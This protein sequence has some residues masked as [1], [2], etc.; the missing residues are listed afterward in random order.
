MKKLSSFLLRSPIASDLENCLPL[1]KAFHAETAEKHGFKFNEDD[2]KFI[3]GAF[4]DGNGICL[5]ADVGDEVAGILC[6]TI[7]PYPLCMS[8]NVFK[9]ILWYVKPEYRGSIGRI[10]YEEMV[11]ECKENGV[12]IVWFANQENYMKEPLEHFY[13]RNGFNPL[14]TSWVKVI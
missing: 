2:A 3:I 1:I 9:E 8:Q 4:I 7:Q 13:A 6:G 14:E 5:V 12:D 10:M 11:Y